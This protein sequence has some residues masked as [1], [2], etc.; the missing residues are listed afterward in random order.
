MVV[1]LG[2]SHQCSRKQISLRGKG[3]L[4]QLSGWAKEAQGPDMDLEN[5][6]VHICTEV[7]EEKGVVG[8]KEYQKK[9][10]YLFFPQ[11][12]NPKDYHNS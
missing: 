8:D 5:C 4:V 10:C 2:P 12:L 3:W 11:G 9:Q 6:L 1:V 7:Q